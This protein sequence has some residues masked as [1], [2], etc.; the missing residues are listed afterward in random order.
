MIER[1]PCL[2]IVRAEIPD[3]NTE[4]D[5]CDIVSNCTIHGPCGKDNNAGCMEDGVCSKG[6]PKSF[7]SETKVTF[8][9][10]TRIDRRFVLRNG[11]SLDIIEM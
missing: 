10:C 9:E 6:F 7:S 1:R 8:K 11:K 5:L 4:P 2:I 3:I